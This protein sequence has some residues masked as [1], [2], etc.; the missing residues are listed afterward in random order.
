MVKQTLWTVM[1]VIWTCDWRRVQ[2]DQVRFHECREPVQMIK[3]K[4]TNQSIDQAISKILS[5]MWSTCLRCCQKLYEN[6]LYPL[7]HPWWKSDWNDEMLSIWSYIGFS[8]IWCTFNNAFL[9]CVPF[10]WKKTSLI[11]PTT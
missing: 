3:N 7:W 1:A 6:L 9:K 10:S 8:L 5:Q 4:S 11:T 2:A